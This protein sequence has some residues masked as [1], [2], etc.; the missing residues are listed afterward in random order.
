MAS[1]ALEADNEGM[2]ARRPRQVA[3]CVG[4][5]ALAVLIAAGYVARD[6]IREEYLIWRLEQGIAGAAESLGRVGSAKAV[7]ALF[8]H[9]ETRAIEE[10]FRRILPGV[11]DPVRDL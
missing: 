9:G 4:A 8:R 11:P 2:D 5:A 10:I 7:P 1:W 6:R 3:L